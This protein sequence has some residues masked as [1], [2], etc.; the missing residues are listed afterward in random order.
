MLLG[1]TSI[2]LFEYRIS[3]HNSRPSINLLPRI[4]APHPSRH[5]LFLLSPPCQVEEEPDPAKLV[6][7]N[8]SSSENQSRNHS[9]SIKKPMFSLF[10]VIIKQNI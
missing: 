4:I 10:D 3:S 7:S 1:G 6:I 9:W 5:P 2:V 8:D